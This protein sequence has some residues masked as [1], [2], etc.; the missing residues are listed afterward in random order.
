MFICKRRQTILSGSDFM[1]QSNRF[2]ITAGSQLDLMLFIQL[3]TELKLQSVS[4]TCSSDLDQSLNFFSQSM[5]QRA[6]WTAAM[7]GWHEWRLSDTLDLITLTDG[8]RRLSERPQDGAKYSDK[9]KVDD[10][11]YLLL[12][13]LTAS[14]PYLC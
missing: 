10:F 13:N 3:W 14:F 7:R 4:F 5:F 9:T 8:M 12:K 11:I 2:Y 6:V 1:Q